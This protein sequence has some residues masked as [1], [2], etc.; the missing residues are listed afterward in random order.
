[1]LDWNV[2]MQ[3]VEASE[4]LYSVGGSSVLRGPS[5]SNDEGASIRWSAESFHNSARWINDFG[6]GVVIGACD[7]SS[8]LVGWIEPFGKVGSTDCITGVLLQVD[9]HSCV[10][11]KAEAI[12][13]SFVQHNQ[14]V[15][16]ISFTNREIIVIH[17]V[18][19]SVT[20]HVLIRDDWAWWDWREF[21]FWI[22]VLD[23]GRV[24]PNLVDFNVVCTIFA[25]ISLAANTNGN[26]AELPPIR[27]ETEEQTSTL[28]PPTSSH[29]VG[30]G[31][32]LH[33]LGHIWVLF[34]LKVICFISGSTS[35]VGIHHFDEEN[36]LSLEW[37][38]LDSDVVNTFH[39]HWEV[40]II[41]IV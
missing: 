41:K 13:L 34:R 16:V 1:M 22:R 18:V 11:V 35:T 20:I 33:I 15:S 10:S 12:D 28:G 32:V 36:W 25:T 26:K 4:A 2:M 30:E 3:L 31:Q 29:V 23:D 8:I 27:L 40:S 5:H 14:R 37:Q 39:V 24:V 7:S 19:G 17:L 21:L 38:S 9:Q 6:P